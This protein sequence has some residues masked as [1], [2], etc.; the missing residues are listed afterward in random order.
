MKVSKIEIYS[1]GKNKDEYG[2]PYYAYKAVIQLSYVS[3]FD[4]ITI[5]QDMQY[6]DSSEWACL[7]WALAGI[8]E[9]LGIELEKNDERIVQYHR[10]VY[11]NK[12]LLH[13]LNW[14]K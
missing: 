3:Y 8:K 13:P 7:G 4:S 2:N 5:C 11:Q 6:G 9:A 10:H 12:D 1:R 14:K